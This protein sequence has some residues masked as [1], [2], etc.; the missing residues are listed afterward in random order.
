[1]P[2]VTELLAHAI[3]DELRQRRTYLDAA[4]ALSS[5]T[6]TVRLQGEPTLRV[7]SVEFSD[8]RIV[9]RRSGQRS[10]VPG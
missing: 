6:V 8:Q 2:T 3:L 9:A 7:R 5:V 10:G 1:M 4:E